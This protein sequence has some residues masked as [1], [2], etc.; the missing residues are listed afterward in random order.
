MEARYY[1]KRL[2]RSSISQL[3]RLKSGRQ[4]LLHQHDRYSKPAAY[5]MAHSAWSADLDAPLATLAKLSLSAS[6]SSEEEGIE[7]P[8]P[9]TDAAVDEEQGKASDEAP[10]V[11]DS[12]RKK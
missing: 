4:A 11:P 9:G 2:P 6:E 3:S 7:W 8:S 12:Q 5:R 1:P 10:N